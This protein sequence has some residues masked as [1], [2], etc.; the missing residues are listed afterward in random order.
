MKTVIEK[1]KDA[2][3][4]ENRKDI[5][6]D[7]VSIHYEKNR[8]SRIVI[9]G[10]FNYQTV[11]KTIGNLPDND[12]IRLI[13]NKKIPMSYFTLLGNHKIMHEKLKELIKNLDNITYL[14]IYEKEAIGIVKIESV[15][16]KRSP[17]VD[18][19]TIKYVF[20]RIEKV[21]LTLGGSD[22]TR[23]VLMKVL[24]IPALDKISPTITKLSLKGKQSKMFN[25]NLLTFLNTVNRSFELNCK[26]ETCLIQLNTSDNFL[27]FDN[28]IYPLTINMKEM[29][30][31]VANFLPEEIRKVLDRFNDYDTTI[32]FVANTK[33]EY[34]KV[35]SKAFTILSKLKPPVP[36]YLSFGEEKFQTKRIIIR[37]SYEK[38]DVNLNLLFQSEGEILLPLSMVIYGNKHKV[39]SIC[40]PNQ[41]AE[42]TKKILKTLKNF[43]GTEAITK[44]TEE[45]QNQE[46]NNIL[47]YLLTDGNYYIITNKELLPTV[48]RSL[49]KFVM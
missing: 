16:D 17:F 41:T 38:L 35:L 39:L 22:K 14:S 40:E 8:L 32:F 37:G 36:E 28:K 3:T 25:Q 12:W 31:Q 1:K 9:S 46:N 5:K 24:N 20:N 13:L 18:K 4:H 23:K 15:P 11:E 10:E 2:D 44:Y 33:K 6:I 21:E 45:L 30:P 34:E 29:Y 26:N 7:T 42:R 48:I 47:Y 49:P 19:I 27:Y 43:L